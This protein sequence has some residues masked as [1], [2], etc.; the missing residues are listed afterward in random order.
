[1]PRAG[2]TFAPMN[3]THCVVHEIEK[4]AGESSARAHYSQQLFDITDD[5][6]SLVEQLARG[7]GGSR[8]VNARFDES[9]GKLFPQKFGDYVQGMPSDEGFLEYTQQVV[10]HLETVIQGKSGAKGGY[11]LL[12]AYDDAEGHR[13]GVFLLRNTVGRIFHRTANGFDVE[14][15]VHLDTNNLAMACRI[16]VGRFRQG[17]GT[18][19]ELTHRSENEVSAY[20]SDWI[21]A[22]ETLSSRQM[23]A[24]L[25]DL[26]GGIE[27]V[28]EAS[29]EVASQAQTFERAYEHVRANPSK[30]VD[31]HELSQ[32]LYG[33]PAKIEEHAR[34]QGIELE[35]EFRYN[36]AAL[37]ELVQ[38][39]AAADGLDL[40]YPRAALEDGVM[41]VEEGDQGL[42][43]VIE[44]DALARKV[45]GE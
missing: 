16:D 21:G 31:I 39:R 43:I 18:Y 3:L 14:P 37:K 4:E 12:C 17:A 33:S 42:R 9:P 5:M 20:F 15:V 26:L 6:R 44:S 19:L 38:L 2:F 10:G 35:T 25:Q 24:S 41:Y 36:P 8:L 34:E 30:V 23:T 7:F 22:E 28:D 32:E 29:G 11:L 1:M 40:K 27:M 13:H 45:L